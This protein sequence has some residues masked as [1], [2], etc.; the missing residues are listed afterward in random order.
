MKYSLVLLTMIF[1][2]TII[3]E[4]KTDPVYAAAFLGRITQ[5]HQEP[6]LPA[7]EPLVCPTDPLPGQTDVFIVQ[8]FGPMY[9]VRGLWS[10]LDDE[11]KRSVIAL[12]DKHGAIETQYN[13]TTTLLICGMDNVEDAFYPYVCDDLVRK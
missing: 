8:V 13:E 12:R 11:Q 9:I 6:Q 4:Q 5:E 1:A 10:R 3:C 7:Q 2:C